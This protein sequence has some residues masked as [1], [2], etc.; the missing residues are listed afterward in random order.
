MAKRWV[1]AVL[2]VAVTSSCGPYI[3]HGWIRAGIP[4]A[5]AQRDLA[6]CQLEAQRVIPDAPPMSSQPRQE[7]VPYGV[8]VGNQGQVY[9]VMV[10]QPQTQRTWQDDLA[11]QMAA[12][13]RVR[14][15][16]E[17]YFETCMRAKGYHWGPL[18][19]QVTPGS[20]EKTRA[21]FEACKQQTGYPSA[22]LM[23]LNPDGSFGYRYEGDDKVFLRCLRDKGHQEQAPKR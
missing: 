5:D 15:S 20:P 3:P 13:N 11:D 9:G 19:S 23:K 7:P 12:D 22:T 18:Q 6:A 4:G 8:V 2:V 1:G 10:A 14:S 21:N 16:R 17:T